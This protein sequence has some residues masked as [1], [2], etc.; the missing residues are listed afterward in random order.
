MRPLKEKISITIDGDLLEKTVTNVHSFSSKVS[1]EA[2]EYDSGKRLTKH[3]FKNEGDL[4]ASIEEIS[5]VTDYSDPFADG[6]VAQYTYTSGNNVLNTTNTYDSYKRISRKIHA[7]SGRVFSSTLQYENTRIK[8]E[9]NSVGGT[10]EYEYDAC[11]RIT[12]VKENN[13]LSTYQYDKIGQLIRENNKHLDKTFIYSYN[14]IG[15][16]TSVKTYAY[17]EAGTAPTGSYTTKSYTYDGTHKDRLTNFN[18]TGISYNTVGCPT[19]YQGKS[20]TW[21]KGKLTGMSSGTFATG[22]RSYSFV[23]NAQGQR[24]TS[25]YKFLEGTSSLTPIETGEV[26]EYTTSYRYDHFGRL[27]SE[28]TTK[29]LYG[30]GSATTKIEYLYDESRAIGF[31]YTYAGVTTPYYYRR[32]LQGDVIEIYDTGNSRVVRYDYDAWGN[33][34]IAS[35]TTDQVIARANPIRYRGYYYDV[36]TQ[37]FYCNSRYYSP[38]LCRWISPD[39]I[40]YLDPQNING[41]NLY[42]YCMN[43]PINYADPSGHWGE[44]VF[45]LFSLGVSIVEVIINPYD[46]LNW[47]G[48]A[49]DALDLIPFVTGVGETVRGV[50]VVAKGVDMADDVYDTIK[51]MKV[52]DLTDDAWDTVRGLDRAGDFTQSSMSAGRR[53]HKG[54]KT[55]DI[56]GKEFRRFR[57]IRLDYFDEAGRLVYELKPYNIN[58]LKAGVSQLA[59]YRRRMGK[60]YTWIL[61]LY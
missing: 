47:A 51:I 42:A 9:I 39:S 30:I 61:E 59:R 23:Y 8:K 58:S 17:A 41:L 10:T 2:F 55:F 54:Y 56:D 20:L 25:S 1:S 46:P 52:A 6:R 28:S 38:E 44:T 57:G 34:T 37:L 12:S 50:K 21:V 3:T 16:I 45:D 11:G 32:N 15:N 14:E 27:H 18:G 43:D 31:R 22:T 29:M 53:I 7:L 19:K 26:I 60:G 13:K 49:G 24:V 5:Y 33:C 35:G 48:L 4:S 36:E 40:E